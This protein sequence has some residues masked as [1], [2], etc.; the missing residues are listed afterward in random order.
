[1]RNIVQGATVEA[2]IDSIDAA[3]FELQRRQRQRVFRP[4]GVL[5]VSCH[6]PEC[7]AG[8]VLYWGILATAGQL[9]SIASYLTNAR[10]AEVE[11]MFNKDGQEVYQ[12]FTVGDGKR[13]TA[14]SPPISFPAGTLFEITLIA[15]DKRDVTTPSS[16][17]LAAEFHLLCPVEEVM[18]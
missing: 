7:T 18:E 11:V 2:Q 5:N 10:V 1:M 13:I 6:T 3:L 16:L 9:V 12:A 4:K 15:A 8:T 14:V 17:A